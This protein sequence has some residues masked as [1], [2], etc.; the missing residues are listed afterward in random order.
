MSVR[1]LGHLDSFASHGKPTGAPDV[2]DRPESES[3][4]WPTGAYPGGDFMLGGDGRFCWP[5]ERGVHVGDPCFGEQSL[6]EFH[7]SRSPLAF[8]DGNDWRPSTLGFLVL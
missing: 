8:S 6:P 4:V 7:E 5:S 3:G 1:V 2:E